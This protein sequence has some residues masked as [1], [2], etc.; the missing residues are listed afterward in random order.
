MNPDNLKR[1]KKLLIG[2]AEY[3]GEAMNETRLQVCSSVLAEQSAEDVERVIGELMRDP[4][5]TRFPL[6]ALIL[7]RI[8][9]KLSIDQAA[10]ELLA[11]VLDAV[12]GFGY[13]QGSKAAE[14]LGPLAWRAVG[15]FTGWE[16]FCASASG[17]D[18]AQLRER[19][20][21]LLAQEYPNGRVE[22]PPA[23][24]Q[25]VLV[26][27]ERLELPTAIAALLPG[28]LRPRDL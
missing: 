12:S 19:L 14:H 5:I 21:G 15:G 23:N 7:E 11:R 13:A 20:K 3:Y 6:P 4:T 27:P 10:Q 26:A 24:S 28:I 17:V 18:K 8:A 25:K 9:P 16:N 2:M 1:I 22:L